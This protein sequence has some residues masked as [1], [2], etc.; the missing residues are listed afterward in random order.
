MRK[1]YHPITHNYLS[2]SYR[3]PMW[4][5][6]NE[7][8]IS[9]GEN[10]CR[11]F[12]NDTLPDR[13]KTAISMINAYPTR[14]YAEW[15]INPINVYINHQDPSLDEIGWRINRSMYMLVLTGEFLE[16][17]ASGRYT[18]SE[19]KEESKSSA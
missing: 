7:Y 19:S 10:H 6:E 15:E 17:V 5:A 3:V 11:M 8:E 4:T 18:R 9:V 1:G 13:V 16:E 2:S 12:T 14:D